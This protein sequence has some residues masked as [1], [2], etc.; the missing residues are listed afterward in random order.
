MSSDPR[1][2]SKSLGWLT[3]STIGLGTKGVAQFT[4]L[5][6][7]AR[8]LGAAEFGVVSVT[9]IVIGLGQAVTV[10]S[11]GPA[12]VQRPDLRDAHV[13]SAF[14][15][16]MY[17]STALVA[18]LWLTAGPISDYFGMTELGLADVTRALA[19]VFAIEAFGVVPEA[20]LQRDM[21]LR[22]LARAEVVSSL[23]GF[24]PVGVALAV[25]GFGLWALVWAHVARALLKTLVLVASRPHPRSLRLDRVATREILYFSGGFVPARLFSYAAS[26]GDNFVVGKWMGAAPL[27]V[28]GR[29]YQLMAMPAMFLGDV[30]DRILFPLLARSQGDIARLR[31]TYSRGVA[32]TSLVMAPAGALGFVLAPE[33]VRVVLGPDW[34]DVIAPFRILIAG[35]LF[36]TGYKIADSLARATGTVYARMWRQAVFAVLV[37]CGALAGT[38]WGL[39]GVAVGIVLAL[40]G[41][42]ALMAWLSVTTTELAWSRFLAL[43]VRGLV[44][45]TVLG[46]LAWITARVIRDA[47]ASAPAVLAVATVVPCVLFLLGTRWSPRHVIGEEGLWLVEKLTGKRR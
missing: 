27:G 19:L 37:F 46:S 6:I 22:G 2:L 7:L 36:R 16:G 41:N 39:S 26:R 40:G 35:L 13:R 14:A 10:A 33:I 11:I 24:V 8:F 5:A 32:L 3:W 21:N 1:R 9:L 43:H 25:S 45:A 18:L 29:A 47:D 42:Y 28:Y 38:S 23:L 30:I 4:L 12:L 44:L 20:L 15:L 17:T 31:A 34:D